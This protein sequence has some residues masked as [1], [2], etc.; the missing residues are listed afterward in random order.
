MCG[1]YRV[2]CLILSEVTTCMYIVKGIERETHPI[3]EVHM[4]YKCKIK[5]IY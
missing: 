1:L 3:L 5:E 2:K 4:L